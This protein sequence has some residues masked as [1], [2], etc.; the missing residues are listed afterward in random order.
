MIAPSLVDRLTKVLGLLGSNHDGEA[1]AAG[2]KA[3]ELVRG[4]GMTWGD[5]LRPALPAPAEMPAWGMTDR[6]KLDLCGEHWDDLGD[7]GRDFISSLTSRLNRGRGLTDKQRA[8]LDRLAGQFT[9]S[10]W[11]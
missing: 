8:A 2:R 10:T 6:Q 11:R 5:L 4:A 3:H 9:R 1:L 7:W